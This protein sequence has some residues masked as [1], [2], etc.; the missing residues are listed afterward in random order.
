MNREHIRLEI[1]KL[2]FVHGRMSNEEVLE[3]AQKFENYVCA[4]QVD[5]QLREIVNAGAEAPKG[6]Q[7]SEASAPTDKR[8]SQKKSGN[9][10]SLL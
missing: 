7:D 10:K 8:Q 4:D 1:L 2:V 5:V 6:V 9:L 3:R